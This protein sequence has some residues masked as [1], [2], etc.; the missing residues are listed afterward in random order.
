MESSS[1]NNTSGRNKNV[2]REPRKMGVRH[3]DGHDHRNTFYDLQKV[4]DEETG[5]DRGLT[6]PHPEAPVHLPGV[7]MHLEMLW[8]M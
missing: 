8:R 2:P 1:R 6:A 5:P 3:N 4:G 7:D